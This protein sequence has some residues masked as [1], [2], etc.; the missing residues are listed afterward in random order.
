MPR[1]RIA[2]AVTLGGVQ[3]TALNEL[4]VRES[5]SARGFRQTRI[6]RGIRKN[7]RQRIHF[8]DVGDAIGVESD[9][10]ARPVT[11]AKHSIGTKHDTL[12]RRCA[13][14]R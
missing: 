6:V 4:V 5:G 13:S 11:T 7:A 9:V 2:D 14:T 10:D 8:D 12:D 3:E 1:R